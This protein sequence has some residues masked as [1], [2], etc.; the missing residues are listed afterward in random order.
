MG[1]LMNEELK[2]ISGTSNPELAKEVADNLNILLTETEIKN[3][4]DGEIYAR[5]LESVRGTDVFVIQPTCP[6]VN[7]NLMELIIIIDALKRSSTA[8]ITAVIPYFG[9]ARQDKKIKP[10]EPI[11]AKLVSRM[12]E[13]AGAKRVIT[14]DL[15]CP[16][17][18]GYFV[19]S[20]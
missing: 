1:N 8:R 5:V 13:I 12:I 18:Q 2:I 16:Q 10:R 3:F 20:F 4:N 9:Y 17:I 11:T 7:Q 14:F 15:H 19:H 6:D